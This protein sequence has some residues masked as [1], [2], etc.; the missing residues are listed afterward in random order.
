MLIE[1]SNRKGKRYK[2]EFANGRIVH[3]GQA[4]GSTYI[5]HGD[6]AK[7]EAYLAR[8]K[9]RENWN[10]PYSA[11]ALSRWLLWGDTTSL[12][13]NHDLFMRMFP[14]TYSKK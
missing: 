12:D 5:D 14:I 7:R 2:V 10:D 4:G 8:H 6:K 13:R 9:K 3:F 11:G 1:K